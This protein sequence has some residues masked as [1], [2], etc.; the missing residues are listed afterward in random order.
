MI[1]GSH[2]LQANGGSQSYSESTAARPWMRA[3]G[4]FMLVAAVFMVVV[5]VTSGA[6]FFSG[7]TYAAISALLGAFLLIA[8]GIISI[9]NRI[10]LKV[11]AH[12]VTLAFW[13]IWKKRIPRDDIKEI[14]MADLNPVKFGGLGL[15]RVPGRTWALL[16]SGGPGLAIT[17][18]SDGATF[19]IRTNHATEAIAAFH[20][21]QLP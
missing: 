5:L 9:L 13:P 10:T 18:E 19:Y 20:G 3:G 2:P 6:S 4:V 14:T 8:F 17:R 12:Q 7:Q 16:F 21:T 1:I 11:D 15:R